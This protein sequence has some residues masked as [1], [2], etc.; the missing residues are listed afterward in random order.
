[1]AQRGSSRSASATRSTSPCYAS[2]ATRGYFR[3]ETATDLPAQF[4]RIQQEIENDANSFYWLN[5]ASPRRSVAPGPWS[6]TL[7]LRDAATGSTCGQTAYSSEGFTSPPR[8]VYV[9]R[10]VQRIY[11]VNTVEVNEAGTEISATTLLG[12]TAPR[13]EWTSSD[14]TQVRVEGIPNTNRAMAYRVGP[15]GRL[16]AITVR[17]V[18][19]S[20]DAA[21]QRF[22]LTFNTSLVVPTS[23][24]ESPDAFGIVQL[25]PNPVRDRFH[26]GIG[27]PARALLEVAIFDMIG[28]Q[29]ARRTVPGASG[30]VEMDLDAHALPSGLYVVRVQADGL[31][32]MR[33][34]VVVR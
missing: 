32:D 30:Y 21:D 33:Q 3:A 14:T 27:V 18:A 13:Y 10:S 5:Y 17:D 19:N 1:M 6:L 4:A 12:S 2:S 24:A 23:P 22:T 11:G 20:I 9:N 25:Y 34:V 7:C 8:G 29:V 15:P 16:A 28:R 31:R 26:L